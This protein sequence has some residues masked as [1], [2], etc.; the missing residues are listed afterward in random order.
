[1]KMFYKTALLTTAISLTAI[2][3]SP[4]AEACASDPYIGSICMF[5]GNFAIRGYA[6]AEGQLLS[7]SQNTALFSILGT[8]YGGDGRT[9][10]GLPDL[11]G[12][13]PI[14]AG[15]GPGL[16][17]I[18]LGEEGG[19]ETVTLSVNNLPAHTHSISTTVTNNQM[20]T[21]STATLKAFAGNASSNVATGKIL[22]NSPRRENIYA[23]GT[24]NVDMSAEAIALDIQVSGD[25]SATSTAGMTGG[26]SAFSVRSPYVG[27]T[28]LIALQGLFPSR[29]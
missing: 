13:T 9:T 14:G 29:S 24:P 27:V 1:M 25:I 18:R 7:I 10:F 3:A 16:S 21:S 2:L 28:Y 6:K 20:F 19:S 5:G 17:S 15:N 11:R 26:N 12:R 23:S 4:K 22:A 8:T